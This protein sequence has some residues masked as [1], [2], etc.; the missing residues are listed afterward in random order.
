MLRRASVVA[1]Q[2]LQFPAAKPFRERALP[3]VG[4]AVAAG[5]A[6]TTADLY[7]QRNAMKVNC[8]QPGGRT[9]YGDRRSLRGGHR[10]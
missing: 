8:N 1:P 2:V 4:W 5:L 9:G 3:W 10:P 7:Q 6:V